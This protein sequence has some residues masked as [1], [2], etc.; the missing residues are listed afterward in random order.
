MKHKVYEGSS[1]T[2]YQTDDELSLII[3]F[4]DDF[5]TE[6]NV[7]LNIPGKGVVNNLLSSFIMNKLDM[8]GI[9]NHLIEQLNMR[10]QLVQLVDV[11]PI[12]VSI[13]TVACGRYITQFGIEE[14]YVFDNPI[15]DFKVKNSD[16]KYPIINESQII[17]FGWLTA[18]EIQQVKHQANRVYDFLTGLFAGVE[19]RLVECKLEFGRVFNGD[20]F[21]TMVVDEISL[22]N[23]RVWDMNT[24]EKFGY[25]STADNPIDGY[26]AVLK[27]FNMRI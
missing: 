6:E 4:T 5:V 12:Q 1:K 3:A 15:I 8:V 10:E 19:L 22:D 23:C 21:I 18:E 20:Q 2:L 27:R 16:L 13:S 7:K 11:Y 25:E 14:G 26:N 24:N 9:D 17:S